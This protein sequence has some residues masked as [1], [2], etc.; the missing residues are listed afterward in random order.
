[1]GERETRFR[2]HEEAPGFRPGPRPPVTERDASVCVRRD[3]AFALAFVPIGVVS[4]AF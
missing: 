4:V 1:M 3:Q 2:V